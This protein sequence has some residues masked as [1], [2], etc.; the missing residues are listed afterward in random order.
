[1]GLGPRVDGQSTDLCPFLTYLNGGQQQ[2]QLREAQSAITEERRM[3]DL[4]VYE[5]GDTKEN[6]HIILSRSMPFGCKS[7]ATRD[8]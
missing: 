3:V 8:I 5:Y 2:L 4:F 7:V 6:V 1:M